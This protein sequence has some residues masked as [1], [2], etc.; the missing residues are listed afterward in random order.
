MLTTGS[1]TNVRPIV[2]ELGP[3]SRTPSA[4]IEPGLGRA[5]LRGIATSPDTN[6]TGAPYA[7]QGTDLSLPHPQ[8]LSI[9]FAKRE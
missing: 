2:H 3:N 4:S 7:N 5:R 8:V 6:L 9:N 1:R